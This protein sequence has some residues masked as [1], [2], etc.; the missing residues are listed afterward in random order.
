VNAATDNVTVGGSVLRRRSISVSAVILALVASVVFAPVLFAAAGVVDVVSRRR[1]WPHVRLLAMVILALAIELVGIIGA[2][3]LWVA[4]GGGRYFH[5]RLA[6]AAH[7]RLQRWWTGSLLTAAEHTV[8][9]RIQVED[10]TPAA[11]GNAI[12]IGRHTSIGDAVIPAVLLGNLLDLHPRY[13]VK[14]TLMW[15]PCIDIV[16]HRL[17]HHFVERNADEQ[18]ERDRRV[19]SHR[20]GPR[21]SDFGGHLPRG[22]LL[23][24]RTSRAFD[25]ARSQ[26]LTP[27]AR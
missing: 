25:R 2:G 18:L 13:V 21:R 15:D 27:R 4:F 26:R 19:A 20:H 3:A 10:P 23:H 11:R 12:V 16:G 9:L 5:T 22:H 14:R 1:G 6:Q 17:P 7:F 24:T 8:G